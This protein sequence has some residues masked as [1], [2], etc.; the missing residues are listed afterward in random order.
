M[1]TLATQLDT[2]FTVPAVGD[3]VVQVTGGMGVLER[4]Q[5][6]GAAYAECGRIADSAVIV[7]NPIAGM[8][9]RIRLA[10]GS[11]TVQADQ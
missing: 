6:A 5:T 10:Y 9:Y 7:S 11:P 4:K 3:F 1:A 8:T 2:A